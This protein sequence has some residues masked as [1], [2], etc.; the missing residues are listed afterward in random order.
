M[1]AACLFVV[2][3]GRCIVPAA[4]GF[5]RAPRPTEICRWHSCF[6]LKSFHLLGY[7]TINCVSSVEQLNTKYEVSILNRYRN[8]EDVPKFQGELRDPSHAPLWVIFWSAD[9]PSHNLFLYKV[10]GDLLDLITSY[11]GV[12]NSKFSNVTLTTF[13]LGVICPDI[14]SILF[15]VSLPKYVSIFT[16]SENIEGLRYPDYQKGHVTQAIPLWGE[17][18]YPHS[19]TW[20]NLFVS[21]MKRVAL[22]IQFIE[23]SKILKSGHVTLTTSPLGVICHAM[24]STYGVQYVCQIR[25]FCLLPF[26]RYRGFQNFKMRPRP[27]PLYTTINFCRYDGHYLCWICL[28]NVKFLSVTVPKILTVPKFPY[29]YIGKISIVHARYHVIYTYEFKFNDIFVFFHTHVS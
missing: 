27:R 10:G 23:G 26:Q 29:I 20:Y 2:R 12:P 25:S 28:P 5:G 18:F 15:P 8:I 22:S 11:R 4:P 21:K 1:R 19:K 3:E 7:C 6:S 14:A 16:P 24:A 17:I 9:G 13:D